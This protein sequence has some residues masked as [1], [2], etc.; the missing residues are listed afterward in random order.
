M[1]AL[2]FLTDFMNICSEAIKVSNVYEY[3]RYTYLTIYLFLS[4]ACEGGNEK[5]L[6][7]FYILVFLFHIFTI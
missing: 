1:V 4:L 2:I 6:L 5:Y 3:S 7:K